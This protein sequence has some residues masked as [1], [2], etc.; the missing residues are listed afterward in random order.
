MS[1]AQLDS[2]SPQEWF[3]FA[4]YFGLKGPYPA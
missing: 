3:S 1:Q 4:Q 2:Q